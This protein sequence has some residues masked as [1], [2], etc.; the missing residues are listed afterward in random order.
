MRKY[1]IGGVALKAFFLGEFHNG[2]PSSRFSVSRKKPRQIVMGAK[3]RASLAGNIPHAKA[4]RVVSGAACPVL[5]VSSKPSENEC[6]RLLATRSTG[7][8]GFVLVAHV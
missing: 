6:V 8:K 1:P 4:Y 2:R 7:K 5:T 3:A